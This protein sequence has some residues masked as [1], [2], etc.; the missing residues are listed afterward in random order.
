M[1]MIGSEHFKVT[2][3]GVVSNVQ[4]GMVNQYLIELTDEDSLQYLYLYEYE[5]NEL[6]SLLEKVKELL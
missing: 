5:V 1:N 4:Y 6:I 3:K 2:K